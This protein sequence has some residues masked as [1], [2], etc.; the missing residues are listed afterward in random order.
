[1]A[2]DVVIGLDAGGTKLLGAAVDARLEVGRRVRREWHGGGRDEVLQ[3][4][5]EAVEEARAGS[6]GA[7]AVAFGIPSLVDFDA[8]VSVQSVHLPIDDLAFRD[9]ISGR[10]GLPVYVDNDANLALLAEHRHGAARGTR[11]AV[12]LTLG[13]GVGGGLV[14]GGELYR[15]SAGAAAELGHM[16]VEIEGRPC[17][18]SCPNRGCLEALASGRALGEEGNRVAREEP[19]SALGR[20]L[21]QGVPISGE[22]VTNLALDGDEAARGAVEEIGRRL[23]AGLVGIVNIFNPEVVVIGGGAARAGDLLL[24]PARAVVLARA[25]RPSRDLARIVPAR[26]GEDA[27]MLGAAIFAFE[28]GRA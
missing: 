8:G 27:G 16:T 1:M 6:P 10:V 19:D 4:M 20:A 23:G 9:V 14:L 17:Q 18:G 24:D 25:L 21:T 12:M 2:G 13:T 26:F 11:H 7:R 5:V 3:T 28:E 15:G 22:L